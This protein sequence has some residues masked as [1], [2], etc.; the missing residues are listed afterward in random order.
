MM[1]YTWEILETSKPSS[2]DGIFEVLL[3][4]RGLDASFLNGSLNDLE[5]HLT[6]KGMDAG[7]TLMAGHLASGNKVV[8]IG[9]YDCDGITSLAQLVHFL[10]DIGYGRYVAIIPQRTEGYGVP[11]R[12]I[13]QNPDARLFVAVDCGTHD[14]KSVSAAR[15]LGADFLVIDHHEVSPNGMAPTTVLINPKQSDC[16]SVFQG[17]LRFGADAPVS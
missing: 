16:P 12:A 6:M 11:E 17:F 5:C 7:A 1:K 8:L 9:D 13:F 14:I 4:N 15:H 3:R 10:R 2:V